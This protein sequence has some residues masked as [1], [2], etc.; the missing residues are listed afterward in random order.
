MP[1]VVAAVA[2]AVSASAGVFTGMT[3]IGAAVTGALIGAA[4]A[5]GTA[6]LMGEDIG[7]AALMGAAIGATGGGLSAYSSGAGLVTSAADKAALATNA[8]ALS[9]GEA[10]TVG[11]N[12]SSAAGATQPVVEGASY[13]QAITDA[14]QIQ[15]DALTKNSW[16]QT[17]TGAISEGAK[18]LLGADA[19]EGGKEKEKSELTP[20][21]G[22]K[23]RNYTKEFK[24]ISES[25]TEQQTTPQLDK[26][27]AKPFIP[28]ETEQKFVPQKR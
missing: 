19:D 27:I 8:E 5:A 9:V 25:L 2:V 7:E 26:R 28:R 12:I 15:A 17:G 11:G 14:A 1:P 23:P 20:G 21:G 6:A 10:A 3:I 4:A 18:Y 13:A 16:I 24:P 22:T